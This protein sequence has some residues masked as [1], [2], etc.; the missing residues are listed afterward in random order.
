MDVLLEILTCKQAWIWLCGDD[1][2]LW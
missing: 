2:W 1:N